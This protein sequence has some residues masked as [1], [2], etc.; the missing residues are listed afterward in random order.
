MTSSELGSMLKNMY[1]KAPKGEAVAHI[2]LFG[3]KYADEIV[4]HRYSIPKIVE[5]SGIR[6][7]FS[8]EVSKGMKLS[9]YAVLK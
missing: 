9:K 8:T 2:H 3:I 7:S 4:K 6:A 5:L 1:D